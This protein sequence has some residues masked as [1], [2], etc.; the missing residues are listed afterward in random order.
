MSRWPIA[1]P[2]SVQIESNVL[3]APLTTMRVGGPAEYF[4][5]AT[6]LNDL[7][8]LIRWANQI[9]LPYLIL[10]GGSNILVSDAGVRGVSHTESLSPYRGGR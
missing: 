7:V 1:P 4:A 2:I 9:S 3:L 10:G 6:S 5:K 8:A